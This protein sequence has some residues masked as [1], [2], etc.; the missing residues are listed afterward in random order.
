MGNIRQVGELACGVFG[1]KQVDD[2]VSVARP[3]WL[4]SSRQTN[5]LPIAFLDEPLN[6]VTAN[7]TERT[8][9]D[10]LILHTLIQIAEKMRPTS[11]VA[12]AQ[13]APVKKPTQ[14]QTPISSRLSLVGILILRFVED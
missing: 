3:V 7:D 9:N 13:P 5:H 12:T 8:D 14:N 11:H 6:D 2:N 1:I 4:L 10:R